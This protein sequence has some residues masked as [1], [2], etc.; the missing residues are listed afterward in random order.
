VHSCIK[1]DVS[2]K[3]GGDLVGFIDLWE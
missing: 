2:L 1:F 3:L